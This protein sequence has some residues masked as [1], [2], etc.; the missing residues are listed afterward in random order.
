MKEYKLSGWPE[1]PVAYQRTAYQRMLHQMSQG[2][3]PLAQLVRASGL[4]RDVVRVFLAQLGQRG[5][6]MERERAGTPL[7]LQMAARPFAWLRRTVTGTRTP[8]T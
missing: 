6:L 5:V 7:A 1:L 8:R 4:S 3:V 2:F